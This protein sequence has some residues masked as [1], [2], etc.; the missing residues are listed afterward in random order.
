MKTLGSITIFCTQCSKS[1]QHDC[2]NTRDFTKM[3]SS[4]TYLFEECF[5]HMTMYL[6]IFP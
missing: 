4:Y 3:G 1:S 6:D 2:K 5:S